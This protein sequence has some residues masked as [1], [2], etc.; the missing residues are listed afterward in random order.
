[1]GLAEKAALRKADLLHEP[2][3]Q[4]GDFIRGRVEREMA[5]IHNMNF[6][7]VPALYSTRVEISHDIKIGSAGSRQGAAGANSPWRMLAESKSAPEK[8]GS[9]SLIAAA[10]SGV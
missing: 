5:P 8:N 6:S 10:T 4:C 1:M 7:V 2:P 3:N 9:F